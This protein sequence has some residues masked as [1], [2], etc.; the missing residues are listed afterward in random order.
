ME[1]KGK[2]GDKGCNVSFRSAY[3]R[4]D[5]DSGRDAFFSPVCEIKICWSWW[6]FRAIHG[7]SSSN[8]CQTELKVALAALAATLAT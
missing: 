4:E 6:A 3:Q 1:N 2:K 7:N 5:G 8:I